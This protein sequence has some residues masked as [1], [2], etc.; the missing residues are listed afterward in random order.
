MVV[1]EHPLSS[2]HLSASDNTSKKPCGGL[3]V[4]VWTAS[5]DFY[6]RVNYYYTILI[7]RV[8]GAEGSNNGWDADEEC[9]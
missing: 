3:E 6:G 7:E 8:V 9:R 2:I 4:E 1:Y 5:Y